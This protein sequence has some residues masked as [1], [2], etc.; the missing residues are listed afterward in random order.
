MTLGFG[1]ILP[2]SKAK[3]A[4]A[5]EV[6]TEPDI[7]AHFVPSGVV[8]SAELAARIVAQAEDDAARIRERAHAEL[9]GLRAQIIADARAH[10]AARLAAEALEL[11]AR[12]ADADERAL[13]R[14]VDLARL[15]A[16][17]LLGETLALEP[18]RIEA[19]ARRA[20]AEAAGARRICIVAHPEDVPHLQAALDAGRFTHVALI[21]SDES[22]TRGSLRFESE[23]GTLDA[24]IAPQLDRLTDHL[25][26][27]LQHGR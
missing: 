12:D 19:I 26:Q 13:T 20:L 25:R 10:A 18:A 16:E 1:K 22:R 24:D 6:P 15:L 2:A 23:I 7:P 11:A 21:R 27:A 5:L 17:R 4:Q 3:S 9:A 14:S 8:D